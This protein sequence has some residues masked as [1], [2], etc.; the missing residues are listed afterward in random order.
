[1]HGSA[2][3]S[4]LRGM[5][6]LPFYLPGDEAISS[7]L[8]ELLHSSAVASIVGTPGAMGQSP[9]IVSKD[10]L[11]HDGLGPDQGLLPLRWN[12]FHGHNVLHEYFAC[13]QRFYFFTLTQ[14]APGLA[15]IEGQQAEIIVLLSKPHGKL[16]S[17]VDAKQFALHCTPIINLFPA[18]TDRLELN[19]AESEF[20]LVPDRACPLDYEVHS[21]QEMHGQQADGGADIAFR[22]L[23]DSLNQ[24]EGN[25][26]RYFSVRRE[27]RLSSDIS[28]KYGTRTSYIGTELFVSLVDQHDAPYPQDLHHLSVQALLTNRDLPQLV[29]RNGLDDLSVADSIP[30]SAVG[31]I[32]A[33]SAPQAPLA[34]RDIAWR[35]IRQLGF[36]YLPL[37]SMNGR[38]GGQALRDLLRLFVGQ[39]ESVSMRQVQSLIGADIAPV[40]R[41]LPGNGPLVYGRGV[42]CRLTVDETGFSG[43]SPY[44]FGLVLE[45]WL[46]RHVSINVFAQTEL[47][48]MQRGQIE[49]WPVRMGTRGGV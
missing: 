8:F 13:P 40:T 25:Y 34:E 19:A 6:R 33:P 31:L 45:H 1:V 30:V 17:H 10:A 16:A 29:P 28:R 14:L 37:T 44:L 11:V 38:E 4:A 3:F 46:A 23:F 15:R 43:I 36:N 24:D 49:C 20:H 5:D 22:P 26:G 12:C 7:H 21:V 48:S 39:Q 35:L 42:V 27:P 18:H 41:R 47:H 9:H 32:C 2:G